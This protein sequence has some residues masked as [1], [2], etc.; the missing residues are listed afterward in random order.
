M[1]PLWGEKKGAA[2]A[3]EITHLLVNYE[4]RQRGRERL[5]V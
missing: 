5:D 4:P 1:L 2:V 3:V